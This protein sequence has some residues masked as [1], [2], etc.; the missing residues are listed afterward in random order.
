M[1]QGS[2]KSAE[3]K[4][5]LQEEYVEPTNPELMTEQEI[6]QEHEE[7]FPEVP[8]QGPRITCSPEV[9]KQLGELEDLKHDLM[10]SR[11]WSRT[12]FMVAMIELIS[13]WWFYVSG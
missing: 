7:N 3:K 5:Q 8:D 13:L 11:W 10:V 9:F 2:K 4:A 12:W 1:G 6:E